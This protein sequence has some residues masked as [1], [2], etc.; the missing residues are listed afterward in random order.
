MKKFL[1]FFVLIVIFLSCSHKKSATGS[2]D[3]I[4]DVNDFMNLFKTI[5]L[6]Y[7]FSDTILTRRGKD[8][9]VPYKIMLQFVPD[10]V[11]SAHFGK[12]SKPKIYSLGSVPVK[13]NE[14]YLF[15]KAITS[16]KKILYILCFDKTNKFVTSMPLI[17]MDGDRS[18]SWIAGMDAKY[19]VSTTRQHKSPDGQLFYRRSVYVFNDV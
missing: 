19:T 16:S 8:S 2:A 9:S 12:G 15:I 17:N 18:V 6:P 7:Q 4:M 5:K 14:T 3:E 13:K 11:F 10:T 1:L